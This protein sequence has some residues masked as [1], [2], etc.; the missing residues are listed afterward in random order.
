MT[1]IL[2]GVSDQIWIKTTAH[3]RQ[4]KGRH[5]EVPFELRCKVPSV[6]RT[7]ELA[8][9][10]KDPD[11]GINDAAVFRELVTDWDMPGADGEKVDF[12]ENNIDLVLDHP[13]YMKAV[14]DAMLE[15]IFGKEA[16]K[17]KNSMAR[18]GS[19]RASR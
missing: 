19:G 12:N 6:T 9:Q 4:D 8:E 17:A 5:I 15:L 14:G 13:D 2:K 10:F 16:L 3:V 11:S 7:K 1:S 18:G